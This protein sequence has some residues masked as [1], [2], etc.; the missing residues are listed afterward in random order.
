M[1]KK[2]YIKKTIYYFIIP[3]LVIAILIL[4]SF[5]FVGCKSKKPEI[6]EQLNIQNDN[7]IKEPLI[8]V[9]NT[10]TNAIE[11]MP[12]EQ[13]LLGVVAGEMP[14]NFPSEALKAQAIIARTFTFYFVANRTSKYQGAD[15]STDISEAQAYSPENINTA[16]KEAVAE[17]Q[18]IILSYDGNFIETWFH[19]NSG[20]KTASTKE[21]F[22]PTGHQPEF[23][24]IATS[25]ETNSNAQNT[26][27][28]LW[29]SRAQILSALSSLGKSVSTVSKIQI[30]EKGPS[31]RTTA[32]KFGDTV[33]SAPEFRTAIGSTKFKST[34][35]T[36]I[37]VDNNG[38]TFSGKGYG[39]GVGLSQWGAKILAQEGKDAQDIIKHYYQN[40]DIIDLY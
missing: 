21:A 38:A 10:Q 20:G 4:A 6:P 22:N 37:T 12:I 2:G 30:Y 7:G 1:E 39:H 27:W 28:S 19:S 34:Y 9:Y 33:V 32:I 25:P 36:N 18:G 8:S 23:I 26:T 3:F 15:I 13:Y 5:S 24:K 35:I 14:N 11:E 29:L 16:I 40:I 31:G 17:T